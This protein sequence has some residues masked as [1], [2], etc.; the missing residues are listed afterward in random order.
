MPKK[1]ISTIVVLAAAMC[2]VLT[3]CNSQKNNNGNQSSSGSNKK[4]SIMTS[5]FPI[6]DFTKEIAGNR[7]NVTNLLP[8][9]ADPHSYEPTPKDMAKI[10]TA[11]LLI[12]NGSGME[13]WIDDAKSSVNQSKVKFLNMS[14]HMD[15]LTL[16]QTHAANVSE[17]GEHHP[18]S[19]DDPHFWQDPV[20]A[21]QMAKEIEQELIKLDPKGKQEYEKNYQ[22][23]VTK[24]D[25]LNQQ[26]KDALKN[27]K[28]K[29]IITSHAAFGY[30]ADRYGLKQVPISG[31][32]PDEEPSPKQIKQIINFAKKNHVHYIMFETLVNPKIGKMVEDKI[33]AKP[34]TLNPIENLTKAEQKKGEDYFSIMRENLKSLKI[35]LGSE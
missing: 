28:N 6:Y 7:A 23:L 33:G 10:S 25:K 17:D 22:A 21:K 18:A 8:S 31:I 9:G 15:L 19:S 3:G 14:K 32:S 16:Q 1:L 11:N 24:L 13:S 34:L 35:A 29:N 26:Y 5:T 4:L 30:L 2:L 27:V 12:Y 20:R